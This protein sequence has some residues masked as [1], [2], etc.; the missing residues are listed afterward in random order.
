MPNPAPALAWGVKKG[1]GPFFWDVKPH[2][3]VAGGCSW[4][5]CSRG[6]PGTPGSVR[7]GPRLEPGELGARQAPGLDT[8]LLIDFWAPDQRRP[9]FHP[10]RP[11]TDSL[12]LDCTSGRQR[13]RRARSDLTLALESK[14]HEQ[15]QHKLLR[16]WGVGE[17]SEAKADQREVRSAPGVRWPGPG[18]MAA[19]SA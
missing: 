11:S 16:V 14:F 1:N 6:T 5:F 4:R 2:P 19:R 17:G 3:E 13:L 7:R 9:W 10:C 18:V 12:S 15:T 8:S